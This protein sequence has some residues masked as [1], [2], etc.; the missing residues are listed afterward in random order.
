MFGGH[1]HLW[2]FPSEVASG[3]NHMNQKLGISRWSHYGAN[4]DVEAAVHLLHELGIQHLREEFPRL[5]FRSTWL[6]L[7][8]FSFYAKKGGM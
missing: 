7:V 1:P 2:F 3:L 6:L 8:P 4:E 5:H